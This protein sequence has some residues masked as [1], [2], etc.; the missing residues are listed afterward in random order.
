MSTKIP[1]PVI[2]LNLNK[3]LS[4]EEMEVEGTNLKWEPPA[5]VFDG[6]E[7]IIIEV[8]LPGI[9]QEDVALSLEDDVLMIEGKRRGVELPG[10]E[11]IQ[12]RGFGGF[13]RL[14]RLPANVESQNAYATLTSGVLRITIPKGVTTLTSQVVAGPETEMDRNSETELDRNYEA[15][16]REKP[17]L[18]A[19]FAGHVVAYLDGKRIAEGKD[20]QDLLQNI[21]EQYRRRS[22][23]IKD[24]PS[25]P[26]I[27]RRP[28]FVGGENA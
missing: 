15:Y 20:A 25:R 24:V 28:F 11:V 16:L 4:S 9:D 19:R 21:P 18:E 5:D 14:I 23:F 7:A 13:R 6:D 1:S 17:Q 26:V 2:S 27:F 8:D 3:Y 10:I 22:L 12:E